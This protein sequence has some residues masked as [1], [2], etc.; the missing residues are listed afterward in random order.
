MMHALRIRCLLALAASSFVAALA[1]SVPITEAGQPMPTDGPQYRACLGGFIVQ[2]GEP[3]P[4][5]PVH[6]P[7]SP[8]PV[9]GGPHGGGLL[10]GILGGLGGIL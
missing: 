4:S 1:F 8:G 9:G 6:R 2:I 3:C 7:P 10:G 5:I